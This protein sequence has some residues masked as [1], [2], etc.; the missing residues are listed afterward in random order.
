MTCRITQIN[1]LI[2]KY[3]SNFYYIQLIDIESSVVEHILNLLLSILSAL[4]NKDYI[5]SYPENTFYYVVFES[6]VL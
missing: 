1:G 4:Y 6:Y 2:S 3:L 5:R